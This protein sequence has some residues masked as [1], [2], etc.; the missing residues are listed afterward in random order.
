MLQPMYNITQ[1]LTALIEKHSGAIEKW[2]E[3]HYRHSHPFYYTSVDIRHAGFKLA[4]VDTNLFPA[5][6]NNLSENAL[7]RAITKTKRYFDSFQPEVE[8]I[9][10]IPEDH[11]R[12]L[13]YLE[14]VYVLANVLRQAGYTVEIGSLTRNEPHTL[15]TISGK[16]LTIA[17]LSKDKGIVHIK[18]SSIT[19]DLILMNNDLSSGAPEFLKDIRQSILPPVGFGWHR[20]R[21]TTHFEAYGQIIQQFCNAFSLDPWLISTIFQ[22]C[23]KVNFKEKAGLECVAVN[24]EKTLSNIRRK[25]QEYGI[26]ETPYV[27]IKADHGTYGMGIM[28]ARSPDEVLTINKKA[29]N[30]MAIIKEGVTNSEVII[31]EG[32]PTVDMVKEK[33]A[34]PIIYLIGGDAIGCT[35]R[36]NENRDAYGN[37]NSPG[38]TFSAACEKDCEAQATS[39]QPLCPAQTLI[40]RLATIA[41]AQECY[42][43][44]WVI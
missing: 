4:P 16:L 5:G 33:A 26:H 9:L 2:L 37:L 23:G 6:F 28:T 14:N 19:P 29:R 40:A 38:M 36:V 41:A 10:L 34:E 35:Y 11:T 3:E 30:K 20:R 12:N 7:K 43:A 42:E 15:T 17:A 24:V 22:R 8:N 27:F 21:K 32:V 31:Q 13:F 39:M 44:G 25:Y 1:R 18:G